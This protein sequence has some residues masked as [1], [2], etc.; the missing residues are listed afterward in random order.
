MKQPDITLTHADRKRLDY[1]ATLI[2]GEA[3]TWRDGWCVWMDGA[4]KWNDNDPDAQR[5]HVRV[6]KLESAI[7][8]LRRLIR[9]ESLG[10]SPRLDAWL[11]LIVWWARASSRFGSG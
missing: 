3:E 9:I 11:F 4:W 7:N 2:H 8:Y 6:A 5:I 1:I 10:P